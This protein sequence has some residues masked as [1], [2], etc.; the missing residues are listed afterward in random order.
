V[1]YGINFNGSEIP[2]TIKRKFAARVRIT[3]PDCGGAGYHLRGGVVTDMVKEPCRTCGP[4][5]SKGPG[6]L[7]YDLKGV[8]TTP[9]DREA[10]IVQASNGTRRLHVVERQTAGAPFYGIYCY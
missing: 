9:A 7:W 2:A 3:C 6:K 4:C 5:R 10:M 1:I 8:A